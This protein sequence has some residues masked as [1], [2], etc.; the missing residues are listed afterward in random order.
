MLKV[1]YLILGAG[2]SGLTFAHQLLKKGCSD[3][4]ILE[5]E[6]VAGGLCRS[7]IVDG[8][9]LDIGGGHFLE[10]RNKECLEFVFKF[11]PEEEWNTFHRVSQININE[12][13]VD[14]PL[15]ANLWQFPIDSQVEYLMSIAKAGCTLQKPQPEDFES[16]IRWKL[17]D[18]ITDEYMLPYN[19]KI[20]AI[21]L[22][23]IGTYWLH[24]LPDVSLKETLHSCLER[25][26]FGHIPAHLNFYYPKKFGYGE[27]WKRM[28]EALG[29]KIIFN[30]ELK[31]INLDTLT[32]NNIQAETVINTIPW[33]TWAKC[34]QLDPKITSIINKLKCASIDV[35][36]YNQS[37]NSKAHWIYEPAESKPYHRILNREKFSTGSK[38]YWTE[39]NSIHGQKGSSKKFHNP[40]AYPINTIGKPELVEELTK[41]ANKK[42]IIPLGRW[43]TWCHINSDVAVS[44]AIQA[45]QNL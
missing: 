29:D 12:N 22:S 27:V 16:W 9:P 32:F 18:K 17:G 25:K 34:T 19:K 24:K 40:F 26:T 7:E 23:E 15:E 21:D 31:T 10:S 13:T 14:Y 28:G 44:Q 8:A 11:M 3:F 38:G 36:Y 5:K 35:D 33:Q 2:P 42:S 4:L 37:L 30:E 45:A 6:S 1:K 20:W 43:G 39:S 41:W